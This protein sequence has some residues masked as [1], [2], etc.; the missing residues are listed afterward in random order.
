VIGSSVMDR[1]ACVTMASAVLGLGAA[2]GAAATDWFGAG[3]E[4]AGAE[5]AGAGW[6]LPAETVGS[7]VLDI[8]A[9]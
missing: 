4:A 7:S 9:A 5:A 2:A 8:S 6:P 1:S 3:A